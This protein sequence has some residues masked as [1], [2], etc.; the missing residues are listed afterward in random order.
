M[1][2][3]IN[4]PLTFL[5]LLVLFFSYGIVC[6]EESSEPIHVEADRMISQEEQNSVVFI[7]NVDARQG[8]V[9]I[10]SQ[11]MT[12]FYTQQDKKSGNSSNQVKRLICK[13]DVEV[14]QGDWL[15]TANRMDYLAKERKVILTGNAK[16]YQGP[17]MVSGKSITYYLDEK[18]SIVEQDKKTTGRVK[19][20]LHPDK[21]K[22]K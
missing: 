12:V 6:G 8:D 10:R 3:I 17:N 18:R 9:T 15:G 2:K 21:D 4:F 11:E 19:A 13:K 14:V 20:V 7:G 5:T 1:N 22:K 16:A